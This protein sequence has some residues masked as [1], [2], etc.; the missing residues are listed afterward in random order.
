MSAS[1]SVTPVDPI[2][3]WTS[4]PL[5]QVDRITLTGDVGETAIA[6]NEVTTSTPNVAVTFRFRVERRA[7]TFRVGSTAGGQDI[8]QAAAF[9][10]GDHIVTLTPGVGT[11]Y[12]RFEIRGVGI[13]YVTDFR[14]LAPAEG[15][16][17]L[18]SP[19]GPDDIPKLRWSQ[20]LNTLWITGAGKEMHVFERRGTNSWSLRPF[21]Q[22][23]GPFNSLNLTN[24]TITPSARTGTVTL[25][26]SAPLFATYDVGS[27]IKLIHSGQ[28]QTADLDAV[29]AVTDPILVT[30]IEASRVFQRSIAGTFSA[31]IVLERS[32]GNDVNWQT[33]STFTGVASGSFDDDLD[34]VVAYYRFRM[35]A[36]TSGSATVSLTY[37]GGLT[38]GIGRVVSVTADNAV[39]VD[40]IQAF[41]QTIATALWQFG[42]WSGRFGH[43]TAVAL[44]DG[45]LWTGRGNQYWGSQSDDFGSF[46]IGPLANQAIGRSFG[47]P[48]SS[49][50]WL[51]GVG[52]LLAGL[53]GFES[54]IGS[55]AYADVL[56][57]ENV[58]AFNKTTKG[59]ADAAPAL[60]DNAAIFISRSRRRIYR[61][62]YSN[63]ATDLERGSVLDLT[64]LNKEIS[65]AGG[66]REMSWQQEPEPRIWAVREDGECGVLVFDM[67]EGV[68]AW[69]RM[70]V[71]GFVESVCCLPSPGEEDEVYFVVRRTVDGDTVRYVEKLAPEAWDTM[72]EAWRLHCAVEYSG[73][74]TD[75]ITGLDHLEARTDVY[76]WAN[77]REEGP[78]TVTGGE[79]TLSFEATYAIAGLKYAGRYKSG[80]LAWGAQMGS[81]LTTKKQLEEIG[82]VIHKTAGG[83]LKWGPGFDDLEQLEDRIADDSLVFDAA[84]Q[85]WNGDYDFNVHSWT[86]P[87]VRLHITMDTA[88]PATVLA[89][90]HV[91]K[92]NG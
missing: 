32:I 58:R 69:C 17:R 20:S 43:P 1:I 14:R 91:L 37:S 51:M 34:N 9:P 28:F 36:Y 26:A 59:S 10:P 4:T 46:E 79:V 85:E 54:E 70:V 24:T 42:A 52:G 38:E 56:K 73:A 23:D 88:G 48:M 67:D 41:G 12:V 8:V 87:D 68:V 3:P 35:S 86:E 25:T 80:R 18:F 75:T 61:F 2:D 66:F 81:A 30:G 55:N 6:E 57:P 62:G 92:V 16:L 5:L 74:A 49:I 90:A 22:V 63:S 39:S 89:V 47:G 64:R 60:A 40:V 65:G 83:A 50:R 53:S 45:R 82:L 15:A 78:F 33:V 84:V 31:T 76:V 27:L 29:D 72:E 11:Y 77:G 21:L 13:A 7:V 19:Y 44:F 71:D